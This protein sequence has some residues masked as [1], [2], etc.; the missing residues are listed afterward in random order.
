MVKVS[1]FIR[2]MFGCKCKDK[3][4]E[5]KDLNEYNSDLEKDI[6]ILERIIK[7]EKF[8]GPEVLGKI[9]FG[10]LHTL[11]SP[12][13]KEIYI[14][15]RNFNLTSQRRAKDFSITTKV[16]TKKWLNEQHDCDEFSFA[17][18]GYWNKGLEQFAFGIAWS[19][20]HAFNI[21]VD[22]N[23]QIWIVEPQTNKFTKVEDMKNNKF[24]Y[25]FRV[26]II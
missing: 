24:Y 9:T 23:K 2:E 21:M 8:V 14:S 15:D 12:H 22:N 11:L 19:N 16:A 7:E 17:L 4:L 1:K 20:A 3:D 5:I 18:M 6:D 10:E 25:P 26:I 13:T